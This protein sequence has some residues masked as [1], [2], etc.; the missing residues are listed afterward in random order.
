MFLKPLAAGVVVE[1]LGV[2]GMHVALDHPL[3]PGVQ[4]DPPE[5]SGPRH[6]VEARW[7]QLGAASGSGVSTS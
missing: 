3:S 1:I 6:I 5:F 2:V 4:K 7:S